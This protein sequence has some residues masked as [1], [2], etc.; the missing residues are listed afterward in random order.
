[1]D[2]GTLQTQAG[3][4]VSFTVRGLLNTL[5]FHAANQYMA[6]KPVFT[7]TDSAVSSGY[8][9]RFI[10]VLQIVDV[11]ISHPEGLY[12]LK[13]D[14][15]R[16][17]LSWAGGEAVAL[18]YGITALVGRFGE[19]IEVQGEGLMGWDAFLLYTRDAV[20]QWLYVKPGGAYVQAVYEPTASCGLGDLKNNLTPL[21]DLDISNALAMT[22]K[23]EDACVTSV[24]ASAFRNITAKKFNP[25]FII[26]MGNSR[27]WVS[28]ADPDSQWYGSYM[29]TTGFIGVNGTNV[30]QIESVTYLGPVAMAAGVRQGDFVYFV[31]DDNNASYQSRLLTA[32][33]IVKFN[34]NTLEWAEVAGLAGWSIFW[35]SLAMAQDN[36]YMV[37]YQSAPSIA[38]RIYALNFAT[39][40][41]TAIA[42]DLGVQR[43]FTMLPGCVT[44]DAGDAPGY[45]AVLATGPDESYFRLVVYDITN[46]VAKSYTLNQK[47]LGDYKGFHSL[48]AIPNVKRF[49][50]TWWLESL[51]FLVGYGNILQWQIP[52]DDKILKLSVDTSAGAFIEGTTCNFRYGGIYFNN[53]SNLYLYCPRISQ[54]IVGKK[55]AVRTGANVGQTT[56]VAAIVNYGNYMQ[57]IFSTAFPYNFTSGIDFYITWTFTLADTMQEEWTE[58]WG[59]GTYLDPA[60]AISDN[61]VYDVIDGKA[62]LSLADNLD[63][64]ALAGAYS[65]DKSKVL[66][67]TPNNIY[68][69]NIS[70]TGNRNQHPDVPVGDNDNKSVRALLEDVA[71]AA[72]SRL[73]PSE[74]Y[75]KLA[76]HPL[77]QGSPLPLYVIHRDQYRYAG[78]WQPLYSFDTI[79][80]G[81]NEYGPVEILN[82]SRKLEIGSPQIHPS[83]ENS[84]AYN[85]F[86]C[87]GPDSRLHVI[88]TDWLVWL[89]P[90]D[91][92]GLEV[93]DEILNCAVLG[94]ETDFEN[95]THRLYLKEYI[96]EGL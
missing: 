69:A 57:I 50:G 90:G 31:H 65:A 88:D 2:L 49:T 15:S 27:W 18:G 6:E 94:T 66:F 29:I 93:G 92:V 54:N 7:K 82:S 47:R 96:E 40:N 44:L 39:G 9:S 3:G 78:Q 84:L 34:V 14:N 37:L 62:V 46:D 22:V 11:D 83:N 77:V 89:E 95:K 20:S 32:W 8:P 25:R 51:T 52:G 13:W 85:I 55:L 60:L 80:V 1:V 4:L 33:K 53:V 42:A 86:A 10:G 41:Y 79:K 71:K 48:A 64:P 72:F 73:V 76:L 26:D 59:R 23:G 43:G 24:Q 61:K 58:D 68:A 87:I 16:K 36:I 56:V 17:T 21:L 38:H 67:A 19:R 30:Y 45:Y 28:S 5:D 70:L 12:E 74:H 75:Q 91:A 63:G 81:D 35:K